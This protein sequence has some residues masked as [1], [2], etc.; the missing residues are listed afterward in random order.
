MGFGSQYS[1]TKGQPHRVAPSAATDRD[2]ER[3]DQE[4]NSAQRRRPAAALV[5]NHH[6]EAGAFTTVVSLVDN[7]SDNPAAW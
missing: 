6:D 5:H 7:L 1:Y 4:A 3:A 2:D